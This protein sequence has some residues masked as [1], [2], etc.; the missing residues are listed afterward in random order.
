[1]RGDSE[2]F[3]RVGP[4]FVPLATYR[5]MKAEKIKQ[6]IKAIIFFGIIVY[7]MA[8]LLWGLL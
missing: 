4:N 7:V 5:L 8:V 1:M 3:I 6:G 2:S